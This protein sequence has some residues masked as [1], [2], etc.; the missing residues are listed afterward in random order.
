MRRSEFN[1]WLMIVCCLGFG[2]AGVYLGDFSQSTVCDPTCRVHSAGTIEP[3]PTFVG[4]LFFLIGVYL[5]VRAL[6]RRRVGGPG[7]FVSGLEVSAEERAR[8]A[9]KAR[10]YYT[11]PSTRLCN[12]ASPSEFDRQML[13]LFD[14]IEA[15]ADDIDAKIE[16]MR[17]YVRQEGYF[18]RR[19]DKHKAML[20]WQ[21]GAASL[22]WVPPTKET[23]QLRCNWNRLLR[24]FGST[25]G[26]SYTVAP[27]WIRPDLGQP[28]VGTP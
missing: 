7:P 6:R 13:A 16:G 21:M 25:W 27:R 5:L 26:S 28:G 22:Q 12:P 1:L 19:K 23:W 24:I 2:L 14:S 18:Q 15:D 9:Q 10:A 20:V 8:V 11:K 17:T 3:L 4:A